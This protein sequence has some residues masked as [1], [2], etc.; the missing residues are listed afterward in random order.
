MLT[1][2]AV[3][4]KKLVQASSEQSRSELNIMSTIIHTAK[5]TK[6][7][8]LSSEPDA[9]W[10]PN[11]HEDPDAGI[12]LGLVTVAVN[13]RDK[14]VLDDIQDGQKL[15]FFPCTWTMKRTF[16]FTQRLLMVVK[17]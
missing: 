16:T 1:A 6:Q 15:F 2:T 11:S 4:A 3:L 14:I 12:L 5:T 13:A 8:N 9:H 17:I 7:T 10:D